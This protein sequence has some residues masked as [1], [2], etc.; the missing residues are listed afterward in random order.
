MKQTNALSPLR[1]AFIAGF[2]LTAIAVG[3]VAQTRF[4]AA[5]AT[6]PNGNVAAPLNTGKNA[7]T[8]MGGSLQINGGFG[9]SGGPFVFN[10]GNVFA[11]QIFTS[12]DTTGSA[13]WTSTSTVFKSNRNNGG[14]TCP[15][16]QYMKSI[17][18]NGNVMCDYVTPMATISVGTDEQIVIH[19]KPNTA[20]W[21]TDGTRGGGSIGS[22]AYAD[23]V[24]FMPSDGKALAI[25]GLTSGDGNARIL[26]AC[27]PGYTPTSNPGY[28]LSD[29]MCIYQQ[30]TASNGYETIV[31]IWDGASGAHG[32]TF[33]LGYAIPGCMSKYATNYNPAANADDGSCTYIPFTL[34][35]TASPASIAVRSGTVV[36][37]T[38]LPSGGSGPYTYNWTFQGVGF[39]NSNPTYAFPPATYA[40]YYGNGPYRM[41]VT[42]T[43]GAETQTVACTP[44][45]TF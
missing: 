13:I 28:I 17:D 1:I 42:V 44:V 14:S 3:A 18:S 43:S 7:Q 27:P 40:A 36:T 12:G 32:W 24:H 2:A 26:N 41:G 22:A 11:G 20:A 15:S 34:T 21:A 16:A 8:K 39:S 33:T 45:T 35:C 25:A 4:T 9:I 31:S 30:P 38:A 37:W 10:T 23:V 6:P 5:T 19:L 29:A